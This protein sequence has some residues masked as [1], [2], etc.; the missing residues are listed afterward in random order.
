MSDA[1][2]RRL[3]QEAGSPAGKPHDNTEKNDICRNDIADE[4]IKAEPAS[5]HNNQIS[6]N[7]YSRF[8]IHPTPGPPML[9]PMPRNRSPS[10]AGN[11]V[12]VGY[13]NEYRSD[14]TVDKNPMIEIAQND[15]S[16]DNMAAL[17][18]THQE[19]LDSHADGLRE[20]TESSQENGIKSEPI[21]A[22]SHSY[23]NERNVYADIGAQANNESASLTTLTPYGG[24][25]VTGLSTNGHLS[26]SGYQVQ[27]L[28]QF[29]AGI[30]STQYN[31]FDNTGHLLPQ[32]D[33]EDFFKNMDRPMAT[34]VSLSGFYS[35]SVENGQ[36]TTL[37][38]TPGLTLAQTYQPTTESSR[39]MTFHSPAYTDS[40]NSYA[41]TQLYGTRVSG[42][43]SQYLSGEDGTRSSPT[44]NSNATWGVSSDSPYSNS[45]ATHGITLSAHKFAYQNDSPNPRE[46]GLSG[47]P[48]QGQFSRTSGINAGT[49]YGSYMAQ[50]VNS[51]MYQN[52]PS[53]YSDVKATGKSFFFYYY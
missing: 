37:T 48:I 52:M 36:Y 7:A 35:G 28:T 26:R 8:N 32:E 46:S 41:L 2:N 4:E 29:Q 20:E 23:A 30:Q 38:N 34:S 11:K 13:E 43:Q 44:P 53:P 45:S 24:H 18:L 39:L 33:V 21:N 50:D 49:A 47:S 12:D 14:Y 27:P 17:A 5:P 19:N 9:T 3:E 25:L 31:I 42:L 16:E 15:M 40:Q 51:W 22:D 6:P 10:P 1:D